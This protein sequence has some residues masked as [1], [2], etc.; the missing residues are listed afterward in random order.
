MRL[1]YSTTGTNDKPEIWKVNSTIPLSLQFNWIKLS[2]IC[3]WK[4]FNLSKILSC[5]I[6]FA[7]HITVII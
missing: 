5:Y 6:V 7:K 2:N 1:N 3:D 4:V